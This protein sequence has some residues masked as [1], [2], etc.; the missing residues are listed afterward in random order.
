MAV[1]VR[2]ATRGDRGTGRDALGS[3]NLSTASGIDGTRS[4]SGD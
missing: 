1:G 3:R 2:H 4:V